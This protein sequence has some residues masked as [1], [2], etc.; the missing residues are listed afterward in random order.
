MNKLFT[1]MRD[2]INGLGWV[3]G[4]YYSEGKPTPVSKKCVAFDDV[5][6]ILNDAE[7]TF[8]SSRVYLLAD[9]YANNMCNFGVDVTK[10]YQTAV[11]NSAML[12]QAYLRGRQDEADRILSRTSPINM[13]NE[14]WI[15]CSDCM[16]PEHDS[17]FVRFKGTPK[18]TSGMFEKTSDVV[19]V[20]VMNSKGDAVTTHATTTDG[21]WSCDLLKID[22]SNKIIA[23]RP[24][25][26]PC[27]R[28]GE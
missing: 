25:P 19:N 14:G 21:R 2:R 10:D 8:N 13:D 18:W 11:Q 17:V 5:L 12:N 3:F 23:W 4:E 22:S 1:Y 7:N 24:L 6:A 9:M 20:T 15:Y 28:K 27:R 16:P 26:E